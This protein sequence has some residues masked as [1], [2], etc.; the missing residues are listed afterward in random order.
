MNSDMPQTGEMLQAGMPPAN[1]RMLTTCFLA[2][3]FHGIV[4]LGVTFSSPNGDAN[5]G[6]GRRVGSRFGQRAGAERRKEP[7]RPVLAR[8]A[9]SWDPAIP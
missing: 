4:I 6:D 2:A 3:L 7:E 5:E 1:D 8:S 9:P